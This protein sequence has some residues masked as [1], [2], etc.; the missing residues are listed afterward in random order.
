MTSIS[1]SI[2][3]SK[4]QNVYIPQLFPVFPTWGNQC[5]TILQY[6]PSS[7]LNFSEYSWQLST[8]CHRF[9]NEVHFPNLIT[10]VGTNYRSTYPGFKNSITM[11]SPTFVPQLPSS[12]SHERPNC[13]QVSFSN[14]LTVFIATFSL[15]ESHVSTSTILSSLRDLI[16]TKA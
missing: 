7:K 8:I 15:I 4:Q 3:L 14:Y 11:S 16:F 12:F 1:F 2:H 10:Y 13:L 9:L 6:P 5:K